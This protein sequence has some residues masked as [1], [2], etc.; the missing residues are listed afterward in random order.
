[1]I[2]LQG[3]PH[4]ER[5]LRLLE[6]KDHRTWPLL[7]DGKLT[8]D[9]LRIHYQQEYVAYVRDFPVLMARVLGAGPPD[10]VRRALAENIFEEQTGKLSGEDAHPTL[11][12]ELMEAAGFPRGGFDAVELL[13]T[14][15]AYRGWL[16]HMTE[17][18]HWLLGYTVMCVFVEGSAKERSALGLAPPTSPP[19]K[20][21]AEAIAAHPLVKHYGVPADKARLT[22]AHFAVE[23]GHRDDAWR[24]VLEHANTPALVAEVEG[25]LESSLAL[26]HIYRDG[27]AARMG[28]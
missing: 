5:W 6:H 28:V 2:N 16:D 27:V 13:P 18:G 7:R 17:R 15:R 20:T 8:R 25:A 23:G 11:F 14:T 24:V 3:F 1:M 22:R 21:A 4:A 12:L 9:Q 10:D 26:W 19:P